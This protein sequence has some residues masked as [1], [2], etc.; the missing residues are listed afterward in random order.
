MHRL[1]SN[2]RCC[3]RAASITRVQLSVLARRRLVVEPWAT[4]IQLVGGR[5]YEVRATAADQP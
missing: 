3:G 1:S 4:E 5:P 2:F